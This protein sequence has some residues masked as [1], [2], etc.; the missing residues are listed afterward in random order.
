MG[1]FALG[2]YHISVQS[3]PRLLTVTDTRLAA[4]V[5]SS[6][7]GK[8]FVQAAQSRD[9]VFGSSGCWVIQRKD[10]DIC[11][12]LEPDRAEQSTL[13][14]PVHISGPFASPCTGMRW[15]L[16]FTREA[17][18]RSLRFDLSLN[19]STARGVGGVPPDRIR[20]L[21]AREAGE[22]FFGFGQQYTFVDAAGSLV[23]IFSREQGIGRGLE[24]I[25]ASLNAL[26]REAG[27]DNR[28]TY[29]AVPHYITSRHR[30]LHLI[31]TEPCQFDLRAH[32]SVEIEISATRMR[33]RMMSAAS[34]LA[35]IETAS[36][37]TGRMAPLP[38]WAHA[39]GVVV[40]I[41]GGTA[42]VAEMA[43]RLL[44][45]GVPLAG[46]WLQDWAGVYE[47][48]ILGMV[49]KRL[50][51]NWRLDETLYPSWPSLVA[52]L[53]ARGVA[54]LTYVNSFLSNATTS[55]APRYP[56]A[57]Q[58]DVLLK[59]ADGLPIEVKSGPGIVAGLLDLTVARGMQ[60]AAE[61]VAEQEP[62]GSCGWMAD[63]GEYVPLDSV[64]LSGASATAV[65]NDYPR[66]WQQANQRAVGAW[67]AT[68]G[69]ETSSHSKLTCPAPL[70]FARSSGLASPGLVPLFWLGDQLHSWDK[71][72]GLASTV[73]G[74][75]SSGLSGHA[76]THSDTGGFTTVAIPGLVN[77]TRSTELLQ[78]WS[79][80]NIFTAFFRTHEGSAP[81]YNA[82]PYEEANLPHFKRCA[83]LFVSLAPYRARLMVEAHE[84]GWPLV[85]P[86]W[87]HYEDDAETVDLDAQ[88]LEGD[89]LLV[90]PV[91]HPHVSRV[92]AYV[93]RG[94]WLRAFAPLNGTAMTSTGEWVELEAP[95]GSPAAL[96]RLDEHGAPPS[97]LLPFLAEA[98]KPTPW[99]TQ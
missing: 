25:T 43:E 39:Q 91:L 8:T 11:D 59:G 12:G 51:W 47:Q 37:Y 80:L 4:A 75:I 62:I 84:R 94:R 14:G 20:F 5:F 83:D 1:K 24:P 97:E 16:N 76:L 78:R 23:P 45:A 74:M 81:Q 56:A 77:Y 73:I 53:S 69:G 10:T 49:Q 89:A 22:R 70:W 61:V 6:I 34:A 64:P 87:V 38:A 46:V 26:G 67:E 19:M 63:Y 42:R 68:R 86:L 29:S 50:Q 96:V 35:L 85:R 88:F 21:Y 13:G 18:D 79:E 3:Q 44:T 66:L 98:A 92:H 15:S 17:E 60:F 82:Q 99:S 36:A 65:H 58:A 41:Q 95:I 2:P 27:G 40:G 7:P 52:N 31:D 32:G 30:S 48:K 33:G 90:A 9:R 72:D 57:R 55:S 93:P 54:M 71:H 28:T